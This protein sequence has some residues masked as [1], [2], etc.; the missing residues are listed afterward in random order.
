MAIQFP[1]TTK[2]KNDWLEKVEVDLKGRS[3]SELDWAVSDHIIMSPFAHSDD[4][5][6][7]NNSLSVSSDNE[8]YISEEFVVDNEEDINMRAIEALQSGATALSF[9]IKNAICDF[10]KL[11]KDIQ[12]EWIFTHIEGSSEVVQKYID[13]INESS[14]DMS[15]VDLS[16]SLSDQSNIHSIQNNPILTKNR[17]C[18][19]VNTNPI[20]VDEEIAELIN[21]ASTQIKHSEDREKI[22][23]QIYFKVNLSDSFYTNVCKIRALKI[24]WNLVI[25][26]YEL[27]QSPAFIKAEMT[28]S[29]PDED[30]DDAKIKAASQSLAA[31]IAGAC[32]IHVPPAVLGK[33]EGFHRRIARNVNHLLQLESFLDRVT[34]PVAGSYYF[35]KLTDEIGMSAWSQFQQKSEEA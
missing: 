13:F 21:Q 27:K 26:S 2:S 16:Y 4:F 35:E 14:F 15:K 6:I 32:L 19:I 22:V 18:S 34:D 7:P 31:A 12:L 33:K 9:I 23:Q 1:F 24:L 8:W 17:F 10:Q 30:G 5:T 11:L 28:N 20:Q 3:L 29:S 25:D